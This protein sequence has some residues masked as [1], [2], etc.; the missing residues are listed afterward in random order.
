MIAVAT[1]KKFPGQTTYTMPSHTNDC[2]ATGKLAG[3]DFSTETIFPVRQRVH[4]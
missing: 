1:V 3:R 2:R 4:D